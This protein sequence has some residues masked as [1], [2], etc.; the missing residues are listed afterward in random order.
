MYC[1]TEI[2]VCSLAPALIITITHFAYPSRDGQAELADV[3]NNRCDVCDVF[4]LCQ[5]VVCVLMQFV[6]DERTANWSNK[7]QN[8][9]LL[10]ARPMH[11]WVCLFPSRTSTET[12][13][14]I[15]TAERV[16]RGFGIPWTRP[17]E[18][19]VIHLLAEIFLS[20]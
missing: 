12:R 9:A 16:A 11:D 2:A 10:T 20:A 14:F 19:V 1:Y 18:F 5:L 8:V 6:V 3:H 7:L 4:E 15:N 13:R 17:Y